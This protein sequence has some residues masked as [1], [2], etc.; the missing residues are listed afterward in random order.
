[1]VIWNEITH[2]VSEKFLIW[3]FTVDEGNKATGEQQQP[4]EKKS[5]NNNNNGGGGK[6][7]IF[8]RIKSNILKK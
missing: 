5:N 4:I 3:I 1:M 2:F 8:I 7:T 6:R